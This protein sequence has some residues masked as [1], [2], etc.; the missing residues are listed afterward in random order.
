MTSVACLYP[1][2][3]TVSWTSDV[4]LP[5]YVHLRRAQLAVLPLREIRQSLSRNGIS[6]EYPVVEDF[7]FVY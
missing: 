1:G 5:V 6:L 4:F 2:S 3:F 7:C